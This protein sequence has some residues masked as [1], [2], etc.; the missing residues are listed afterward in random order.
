MISVLIPS[1]NN[2]KTLPM[3]ITS[4]LEANSVNE[5]IIIDDNSNDETEGLV[6]SIKNSTD[7]VKYF[8]N[9]KS[10]GSG[11][12]FVKALKNSLSPFVLTLDPNNFVNPVGID[13]LMDFLLKNN[14]EV[15][16][17]KMAIKKDS[18]IFEYT[19]PGN[20]ESDY[21]SNRNELKDLFMYGMYMPS[22]GTIIN[23]KKIIDF[24]D[25]N[26]IKKLSNDFGANFQAENYDLLLNLSSKKARTGFLNQ[27][28][29]IWDSNKNK[30]TKKFSEQIFSGKKCFSDAGPYEEAFLF[31]KYYYNEDNYDNHVKFR[32]VNRLRKKFENPKGKL[33]GVENNL[34]RHF[35]DFI[36]RTNLQTKVKYKNEKNHSN[37]VMGF[38][39]GH[40]VSYCI[41][42]NGKPL[43]H[44]ELERFTRIKEPIGDGLKF[45]FDSN[46]N[47]KEQISNFAFGNFGGRSGISTN[48]L[49]KKWETEC[50]DS[51][52]DKLMQKIIKKKSGQ[53]QEFS[54]HLAHA[55]NAFFSSNFKESLILTIDGGGCQS[56]GSI[57]CTTVYKGKEKNINELKVYNFSDFNLGIGWNFVTKHFGLSIGSPKGNQAGTVMAM[58]SMSN[59]EKYVDQIIEIMTSDIIPQNNRFLYSGQSQLSEKLFGKEELTEQ[60]MFDI[61]SSLQKGT[62]ILFKNLISEYLKSSPSEYLCVSGG[63]ALNSVLIG[64]IK[65][66]FPQIKEVYVPPVPYDAGLAIGSAQF[67][68]HQIMGK[69]RVVWK[70]NFTPYLGRI[71]SENEIKKSLKKFEGF[72]KFEKVDDSRVLELIKNQNIVSVFGGGS[73]SGRR[74]LGNR[75]IL[76]DPRDSKMKKLI[77]D[78]VKHRQWFRPFAPSILREKVHEW[79]EDDASSPY[80][81]HVLKWRSNKRKLVPAV[82]HYD[83]TARLQ[84]VTIKDNKWYYNFLRDWE[85]ISG[86]P[87]LLNTSFNDSEPI[88]ETP[89]HAIKCFLKTKINYL[90]FFDYNILISK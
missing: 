11:L 15:A 49:A 80:M 82:V 71:Y 52:S 78:E 25:E 75:S 1:Y 10:V 45:Y 23:K 88:V 28:V 56:D 72:L 7:K 36:K 84:T 90:Y 66:W 55:A 73:E 76:A 20:V 17:G 31:N 38:Q 12:S 19:H 43:I 83:N 27:V 39:S 34:F 65:T 46:K 79:F 8:R 57:T 70:D 68:W 4:V 16:Y 42:E 69:E 63:C 24:C 33:I 61:S 86:V 59:S 77:N 85:K 41:L 62:E 13:N 2:V 51:K 47:K 54:H 67:L 26:Y 53:F 32:I 58:S 18:G 6:N 35:E 74:A 81:T 3:A 22:F 30:E 40:D 9:N 37:K 21:V 60:K 29:C 5:V 64:K 87:I 89:D 44:E 14:L 48:F 50:N